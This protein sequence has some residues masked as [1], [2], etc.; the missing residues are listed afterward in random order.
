MPAIVMKALARM[1]LLSPAL[2]RE[3]FMARSVQPDTIIRYTIKA[4]LRCEFVHTERYDYF[5]VPGQYRY[6]TH[7]ISY[8]I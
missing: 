7:L 5:T 4:P 1:D 6:K 3:T 8:E 2:V